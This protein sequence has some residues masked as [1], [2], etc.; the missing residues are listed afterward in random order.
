MGGGQF[1]PHQRARAELISFHIQ[2]RRTVWA[3]KEGE[4]EYLELNA[5]S[6]TQVALLG[7][8]RQN[9][10]KPG[11]G[12]PLNDLLKQ[13]DP[14][15][16]ERALLTSAA[17][18]FGHEQAGR[19]AAPF[20]GE[21]VAAALPEEQARVSPP[22]GDLVLRILGGEHSNLL[23]EWLKMAAAAA[24]IAPPEVLPGLLAI[25]VTKPDWREDIL[26]V[27]GQRGRWL[28]AQNPAWS[29]VAGAATKDDNLWQVGD[30]LARL[31]FLR[32]LRGRQ[33]ERARELLAGTW[34]EETPEDRAAF[35]G[36]LEAG[37]SPGDEPFLETALDD[38]RKE[39]RRAAAA[40]LARVPGSALGSRMSARVERLVA[41][42]PGEPG[43]LLKKAKPARVDVTLPAECDRAMQRDGIDVK[44]AH[45]FG[46]KSWWLIQM[47]ECVPLT[48]WTGRWQTSPSEIVKASQAGDW[49]K[50]LFEGWTRAAVRQR[51]AAWADALFSHALAA[52][53]FD[54]LEDLLTAL[55]E[56][57]REAQIASVL[58]D[59]SAKT[60]ALHGV[61]LTQCRHEW[62]PEFS[63]SFMSWLRAL[64]SERSGDWQSRNQLSQFATRLAP[65]V[66][67]TALSGWKTGTDTWDFWAKGMDQFLS[68]VQFRADMHAGLN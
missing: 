3:V 25:G 53:R 36:V 50:E 55:P 6:L 39:T 34:K 47:L 5:A 7:T 48:D 16:R 11:A 56:P 14:A 61:L 18:V 68:V 2:P 1:P 63:R 58:L 19:P 43:R 57:R 46:E 15:Q 35:L 29:W 37:L 62:S 64:V 20:S 30:R 51:D 65:Q 52:E 38:K 23:P 27:L 40:L 13:V 54:K 41:F 49:G 17:L 21:A 10:P 31:L 67:S 28:A 66:L 45:G 4:T 24:Q 8:E 59:G 12:G 22:A 26:H 60:K 44:P 42:F 32:L 9:L 33:P